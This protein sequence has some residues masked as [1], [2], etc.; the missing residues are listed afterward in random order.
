MAGASHRDR[1]S[2]F[3]QYTG[4]GGANSN[5]TKGKAQPIPTVQRERRSQFNGIT[6]TRLPVIIAMAGS[7]SW[8]KT[9]NYND[10]MGGKPS[11]FLIQNHV[12]QS[13]DV[14]HVDTTLLVHVCCLRVI[15]WSIATTQDVHQRRH[16]SNSN[17]L[18]AVHIAQ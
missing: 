8:K 15:L 17:C 14:I 10:K 16:V 12:D 1:R 9:I 4:K 18:V 7:T 13:V 11:S 2:Q 5:R 6:K 3:Q